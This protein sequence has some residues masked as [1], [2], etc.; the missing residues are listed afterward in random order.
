LKSIP[1]NLLN[2]I[3]NLLLVSTAAANGK[4]CSRGLR[5]TFSI[6]WR[7]VTRRHIRLL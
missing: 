6:A 7:P 3:I 4:G 2:E 5:I 1:P